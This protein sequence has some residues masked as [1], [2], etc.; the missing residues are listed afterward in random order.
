MP[1]VPIRVLSG[2]EEA[3]YSAMGVLCG[4]PS[5][6]GILADIGGGSLELVRLDKGTRGVIPHA[7][8]RRDQ[9]CGTR[10]RRSGARAGD[11]RCRSRHGAVARRGR[12]PRPLSGGRRVAGAGAHPHGADRLSAADG[13]P[14]HDRPRGGARPDRRDRGR[15]ASRART[16]AGAVAPAH[17][18]SAV[19]RGGA[20]PRAARDRRAARGVQCQRPARGLVHA[21]DAGGDPRAGSAAGRGARSTR[22][23]GARS[24]P[25]AGTCSPGPIRC[26]RRRPAR[27]AGCARRRAGCPTSAATTI[28][29]SVPSRR[30]SA[31]CV[32]PASGWTTTRA[33][34]SRWSPP[35]DTRWMRMR[36]SCVRRGCCW[37]CPAPIGRS[38]SASRCGWPT[39]CPPGPRICWPARACWLSGSRLILRLEEDSGV[40]AGESVMRRLDRLAQAVG[41]EAATETARESAA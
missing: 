32:S 41:L 12:E 24:H 28:R 22:A 1:D 11:R 37:I 20:A 6:D 14:L 7:E 10:R 34:F 4:I 33:H 39:R 35:C 27:R 8:P 17:R 15:R 9:A 16:P 23:A 29:S 30:S 25:A 5:A 19:R 40:F 3:E 21:A 13:A 36:C 2:L 18:R 26:F 38:C 31:C